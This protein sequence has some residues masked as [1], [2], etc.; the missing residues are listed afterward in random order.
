MVSPV[1]RAAAAVVTRNDFLSV[2]LIGKV[3]FADSPQC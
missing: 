3:S 1:T 2:F